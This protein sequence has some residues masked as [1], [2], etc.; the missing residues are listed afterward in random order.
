M[1]FFKIKGEGHNGGSTFVIDIS[2]HDIK[3]SFELSINK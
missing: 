3:E 1:Q 2:K